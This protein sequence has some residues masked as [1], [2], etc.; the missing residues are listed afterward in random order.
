MVDESSKD[1]EENVPLNP[2]SEQKLMEKIIYG[3]RTIQ[4]IGIY[5][6]AND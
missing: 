4:C 2:S 3:R 6:T 5:Q 1:I